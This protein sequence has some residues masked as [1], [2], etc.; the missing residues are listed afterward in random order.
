MLPRAMARNKTSFIAFQ[1]LSDW[2]SY[3]WL[4]KWPA[5]EATRRRPWA[6]SEFPQ[7]I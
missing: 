6:R 3:K 7:T 5:S 2:V 4:H 1:Y